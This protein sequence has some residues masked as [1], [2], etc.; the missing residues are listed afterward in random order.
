M[1]CNE[2]DEL[3]ALFGYGVAVEDKIFIAESFRKP[4]V[5]PQTE[6][7]NKEIPL[8]PSENTD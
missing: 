8:Y 6:P 4:E 3:S 5:A 2:C 1:P 7:S